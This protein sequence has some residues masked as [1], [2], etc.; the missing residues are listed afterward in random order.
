MSEGFLLVTPPRVMEQHQE[1]LL[2]QADQVDQADAQIA[3]PSAEQVRRADQVFSA[4][5]KTEDGLTTILGVTTGILVLHD[6]AIDRF[7]SHGD[8][9]EIPEPK[10][11][12]EEKE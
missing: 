11:E 10:D 2:I 5:K 3:T 8:E 1:R 12:P 6:M 9:P 7:T 4:E